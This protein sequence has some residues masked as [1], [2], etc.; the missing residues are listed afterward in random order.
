MSTG[1]L[2]DLTALWRAEPDQKERK[3]LEQ[4]ARQARRRGR[5]ADYADIA[6][7]AFLIGSSIVAAFA[8]RSPLLL[9]AAVILIVATVWLTFKRR[10]IRQMTRSL[11]TADRRGFIDSSVRNAKANLRRNL[12]SL[13]F[14]PAIAPLALLVKLGS[15]TGG[16]PQAIVVGL[17]QW[18][19]ST[20]GLITLTIMFLIIAF[21]VRSRRRY[22]AE[23]RQLKDLQNA[24]EDEARRDA[25]G[26]L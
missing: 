2:D 25:G 13:V 22:H 6:F 8:S 26:E 17:I 12:L 18:A 24:Y 21:L 23:L 7:V 16:D 3:E 9:G 14:L 11:N 1:D 4:L 19:G 5:L 15:R 10:G 20:R